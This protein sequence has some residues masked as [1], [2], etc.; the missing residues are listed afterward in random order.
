MKAPLVL[1]M[2]APWIVTPIYCLFGG[3]DLGMHIGTLSAWALWP[4]AIGVSV[5]I[6]Y[7]QGQEDERI[8]KHLGVEE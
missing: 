3:I 4:L 8:E 2:L 6:A 1:A 7:R 5:Y